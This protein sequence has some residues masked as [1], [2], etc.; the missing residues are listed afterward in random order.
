MAAILAAH[1]IAE[2]A[3]DAMFLQKVP[4]KWL[5]LVYIALAVLAYVG[6]QGNQRLVRRVGREHALVS[7]LMAAAFGTALFYIVRSSAQAAFGLYLWTGLL[8]TIVVVQFWMLAG[9]QFT[10][11]EA[12]RVFGTYSA[13]SPSSPRCRVASRSAASPRP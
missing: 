11:S 5:S 1:T 4:T 9:S 13:T 7:T 6:L 10:T 3:R 2:T 8:G 12:K